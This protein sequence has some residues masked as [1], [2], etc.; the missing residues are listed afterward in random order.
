MRAVSVDEDV[1]AEISEVATA[2]GYASDVI[3]GVLTA[4]AKDIGRTYD[5]LILRP[6]D[7]PERRIYIRQVEA[8]GIVEA[9]CEDRG[10]EVRIIRLRVEVFTL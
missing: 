10:S 6:P 7:H 2:K 8:L 4:I 9:I 1:R 3:E 5:R